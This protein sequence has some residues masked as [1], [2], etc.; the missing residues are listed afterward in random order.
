MK[1]L[2]YI[3]TGVLTLV[4]I[5]LNATTLADCQT[6]CGTTTS[7]YCNCDN[8]GKA[9][10]EEST[11]CS[12]NAYISESACKKA[13]PGKTC[14]RAAHTYRYFQCYACESEDVKNLNIGSNQT[15]G[16][17]GPTSDG[18]GYYSYSTVCAADNLGTFSVTCFLPD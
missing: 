8:N 3:T 14:S 4:P 9:R 7:T 2:I 1:K 13:N 18:R 11:D 17:G 16:G 6:K 12:H 5:S 15:C 10:C